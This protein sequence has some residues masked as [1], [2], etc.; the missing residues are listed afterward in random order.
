M[1]RRSAVVEAGGAT[2]GMDT[3]WTGL[4]IG[5]VNCDGEERRTKKNKMVPFITGGNR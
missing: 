1:L 3:A 5:S 4:G 2:V